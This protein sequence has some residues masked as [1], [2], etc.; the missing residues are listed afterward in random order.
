MLS[1]ALR[2]EMKRESRLVHCATKYLPLTK[3]YRKIQYNNLPGG[4]FSFGHSTL[5]PRC[6]RY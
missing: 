3:L 1:V 2:Y 6:A 5:Y 4:L